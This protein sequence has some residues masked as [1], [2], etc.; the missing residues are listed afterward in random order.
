MY[1]NTLGAKV[2]EYHKILSNNYLSKISH[3]KK[4]LLATITPRKSNSRENTK[5]ENL[6]LLKKNNII[7]TKNLSKP[8]ME[9]STI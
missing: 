9:F 6:E 4:S 2:K 8:G 1:P 7:L 5:K 3:S